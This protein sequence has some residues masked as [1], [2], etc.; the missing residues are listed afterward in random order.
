MECDLLTTDCDPPA[1]S[2]PLLLHEFFE[3]SASKWPD[4]V[5]VDVPPGVARPVRRTVT[6]AVL[7]RQANSLARELS[8]LVTRE[9]VIAILLPRDS[10]Y[11]YSSQLAIL[12]SGAAHVC[13]DPAFPDDQIQEILADSGA[14]ALMT[15]SNG[16]ARAEQSQFGIRKLIDV[17]E[18][19]R[20]ADEMLI[21]PPR[22]EWL[23]QDSLAYIIYTSGTT[24]RPKGVMIAHRS[25]VNLIRSDVQEFSLSCEDRV[26]QGSSAA[27][28]SSL[29]ETWL[30][31]AAGAAIVVMDEEVVR[32]GP[33][34]IPW[35]RRE[36]IT[37]LCPPP[38]LL[39]AT[40]CERPEQELPDLRLL[41]VGGE[42]LPRDVADR[43]A[44]GR[45]MVNG[46][47]PTECT[48]TSL[49]ADILPAQ[50]ITIGWP[51]P[52][53]QAWV[54]DASLEQVTDGT[55]GELC[56]G[57]IGLALGYRNQPELNAAKFPTHPIFGRIYRT[58]D[59]VHRQSDGAFCY[60]GRIDSQ[61]KLRG[62]RIELEAIE[63]CLSG[64]VGVREA[65]CRMQGD[66]AQQ[67]IAAFIVPVDVE[68]PPSFDELKMVLGR[69]LP[70]YMVP[71]IFGILAEL[72]KSVGGKV[73]RDALPDLDP[74]QRREGRNLRLPRNE[75]ESKLAYAFCSTLRIQGDISVD[76]DFF[77]ELGGS[78]L[79]AAQLV[80]L[81]RDDPSTASLTVRDVYEMRT[82]AGLA[83]R[84]CPESRTSQPKESRLDE[85]SV[86][87][88]M[89]TTVQIVWLLLELIVSTS[90][91]YLIAFELLPELLGNLG[92]VALVLL[93][94]PLIFASLLVY[95]PVSVMAAVLA[96]RLL[97]GQYR[98]QRAPVWGSFY[99]RNWIVQQVVRAVPW[100]LLA[101]TEFQVMVL[102]ALGARIG[103]RVHIHRGVD[104]LQGGWDL[105][106][107]GDDVT[108]G[109]DATLRIVDLEDRHVVV[110]PISLGKGA[111]LEVRAG[112]GP[113]TCLEP[114][115][116]LTALSSLPTGG[117]IPCG[118]RWDG[119]PAQPAGAA[120]PAQA[121]PNISTVFEPVAHGIILILAKFL[122]WSLLTLP[123]E[124][125]VVIC[126]LQLGLEP[127]T[128]IETLL[129]TTLSAPTILGTPTILA[130]MAAVIFSLPFTLAL[131]AIAVRALGRVPEGVI[132]R[133]SLATIRVWLKV[134]LVDSASAWLSGA[135]F[136][137]L[138]LRLAG[139]RVGPG[140]EISTIIDVVPELVEIGPQSF[141]ADGIYLGGPKIHRGAVTLAKVVL[142]K[143]TFLGNHVVIAGGQTLPED[144]LLGVCTVAD[145]SIIRPGS[146]WF[147]HPPFELPRRE[148]VQ[149][150]RRLTHDP[151]PIRFLNRLFWEFLRFALPIVP[152]VILCVWLSAV[153][154]ARANL[155]ASVFLFVAL[156]LLSLVSSG[157]PSLLILV[158][159][160]SLLGRVRP[161][162]HALWSCWCSRWDF[163]YVAW[164]VFGR[165]S[166]SAL[167]GTE[168]LT[169]Y[170]RAMGMKLGK[171]VVLGQGFAQVV[172]PD[173]LE[174]ENGATINAMFQAHTFEDRVLKIDRIHVGRQS[175]L[176]SGTVPL[177]GAQIG[178]R[179]VV[180]P[181][182]VIMKRERLLPDNRYEGAP[183]KPQRNRDDMGSTTVPS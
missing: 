89:A 98:P 7:K 71:S 32:L 93:T 87:T 173:M 84:V 54:L 150:D 22:P 72:P 137:P 40:G 167:T 138:W 63:T 144:I 142:G 130:L 81:L 177:Y 50:P 43:W 73:K 113:H 146:S 183:T 114:E 18:H 4:A 95:A 163:L 52:N 44:K 56:L 175:T 108:I 179:T 60:H 164:G 162:T 13:I 112:M 30:A 132:S 159:K 136:W 17:A 122:L 37:V 126:V 65:A 116:Y 121:I 19:A 145:A 49:R 96:K 64:C 90:I 109:Q 128:V 123:L 103:Q 58:G 135:M 165:G 152:L 39:R 140:C 107:I 86:N 11:V 97:I 115:A 94:T 153:A 66:G 118:E 119:I 20:R 79:Q 104:L 154:H 34:L 6:Y 117:R 105:L 8:P 178:E 143:N 83:G 111:T 67:A 46:Y 131:E 45:R 15:D 47:G 23:T 29:E 36:R 157:L 168:M 148:I 75:I 92:P 158:L 174:I 99:V 78:S 181:H 51:V 25:I 1:S 176:A 133:W 76:E 41:Y 155:P 14:L 16:V 27:Y 139:M 61:V 33:D 169:W 35:L 106:D 80:S 127:E 166:L 62:Y 160:W 26:A 125:M 110:G 59:L 42:A 24:G 2:E 172:D 100:Q 182:S 21:S 85:P 31:L 149:T 151:S 102:R 171:G 120:P 161:G 12:S 156:P 141:L 69:S 70:A 57:G 48:V 53:I 170:L 147:G 129:L 134:S 68:S 82:V 77:K 74:S 9:C 5:S 10:E 124:L 3:Q 91:A 88:L 38:T 180:A 101:G 28:D 55:Q